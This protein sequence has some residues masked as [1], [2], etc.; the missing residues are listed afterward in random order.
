[1]SIAQIKN[2]CL[3]K[4]RDRQGTGKKYH[5]K[6]DLK[7]YFKCSVRANLNAQLAGDTA[8]FIVGNFHGCPV[9]D[10]RFGGAD[11]YTGST[12]DAFIFMP[13]NILCQGLELN[14]KPGKV[15][16]AIINGFLFAGNFHH[17]F[18]RLLW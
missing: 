13:F 15:I 16:E 10:A 2:A 6:K 5:M 14:P 1:M 8:F 3:A 17:Q 18:T 11:G 7:L 9:H 4:K 12:R